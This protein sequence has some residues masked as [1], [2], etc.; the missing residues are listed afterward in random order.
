MGTTPENVGAFE[1]IPSIEPSLL[2]AGETI[3][4]IE[5][6]GSDTLYIG[7]NNG[8]I[9]DYKLLPTNEVQENTPLTHLRR[10][11]ELCPRLHKAPVSFLRSA[12]AL[13]RLLV[14][15]DSTLSVLNTT[16]LTPLSSLAGAS[17]LKGVVAC[18]MNENPI[19][20]DPFSVQ[21]CLAKRKQLAVISI[22]ESQI[23]VDR[24]RDMSEPVRAVGMDGHHICAALAAHYIVY[25]VE[26]GACQ[27]LFPFEEDQ[28]PIVTRIAKEEF[29]L[30]APGGLGMFVT[31]STGISERPPIQ[32]MQGSRLR[33]VKKCI[34]YDPYIVA[35]TTSNSDADENSG[36]AIIVYSILDQKAKQTMQFFGGNAI[37]NFDGHLLVSSSKSVYKIQPISADIQIESLL[38]NGMI[39]EALSLAE[40]NQ[41]QLHSRKNELEGLEDTYERSK[42]ELS[43]Y[44]AY[45]MA[46]FF[47]MKAM[48]LVRAKYLFEKGCLDPR[49]LICLWPRL[50]PSSSSFT[51]CITPRPLH[52]IADVNQL[53]LTTSGYRY[54]STSGGSHKNENLEKLSD[55]LILVLEDR[56][57]KEGQGSMF[58]CEIDTAL[59]KLYAKDKPTEL[60]TF[61]NGGGNVGGW[62][63]LA[64]DY[65]DCS[66][67]LSNIN[68]RHALGLL[69]WRMNKENQAFHT[70]A[71]LLHEAKDEHFPGLDFFVSR[72]MYSNADLIWRYADTV[73]NKDEKL[74]VKLFI[75]LLNIRDAASEE[76]ENIKLRDQIISF[77]KPQ[78]TLA[79]FLFLEHLV[80]EEKLQ[81][82]K[83]H[84]QLA[85]AYLDEI[86]KKSG[87]NDIVKKSKNITE[88]NSKF[89]TKDTSK[90]D[91]KANSQFYTSEHLEQPDERK[92]Q[93]YV[94]ID[95]EENELQTTTLRQK[96]QALIVASCLIKLPFLL[97]VLEKDFKGFHQEKALILGRMGDH[98]KA[99]KIFVHDLK[100]FSAAEEYCDKIVE[101]SYTPIDTLNSNILMDNNQ[102]NRDSSQSE[103][104]LHS[105]MGSSKCGSNWETTTS[106]NKSPRLFNMLLEVYLDK[107][108]PKEQQEELTSPALDLLQRRAKEMDPVAVLRIL[109]DHWSITALLPALNSMVR[110]KIHDR[111]MSSV[112]KHLAEA[113]H[114]NL[115]QEELQLIENPIFILENSYCMVCKKNFRCPK[116][117]R[118]PNGVVLHPECIK[119]VSICP[120][121]GQIFN[122]EKLT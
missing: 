91:N 44:R 116:V 30:C 28:M 115:Q 27:D 112:K 119:D 67:Y 66:S 99:L 45:Q 95:T 52:E 82:E 15:C 6:S 49:E 48:D 31:A 77:M 40:R 33:E 122:M 42:L 78:Y 73:L 103:R 121:T 109:P 47:H 65:D 100:D 39:E 104:Q 13:D 117:S 85:L 10:V 57:S 2:P 61:L 3:S 110:S 96:F 17:K 79:S 14:L 26:T 23:K 74:G 108:L 75:Q 32:W 56:R 113:E 93:F 8:L 107:E 51:R 46:G 87:I 58:K 12:S 86:R 35:L 98:V 53:A 37:G 76:D 1:L 29:L 5:L 43:V 11:K 72:L 25:N 90:E 7:T 92:S 36:D 69:N 118:Y 21:L 105:G 4:T 16:D 80:N 120:I 84:T 64:A 9:L 63:D 68:R 88:T 18:C 89:Y 38:T 114:L 94:S 34:F 55:F 97:S 102:S 22:S 19:T 62:P 41:S 101:S 83:Y 20:D 24:I 59:I 60:I 54:T 70:W 111:R 71:E 106:S 50:L 81:V